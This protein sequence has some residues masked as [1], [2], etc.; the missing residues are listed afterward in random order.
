MRIRPALP[1]DANAI[2]RVHVQAWQE[3]YRG[4]MPDAVLDTISVAERAKSWSERIPSLAERRQSVVVAPNDTGELIGFAGCGP[5]RLPELGADGEIYMINIV[6]RGKRQR[7][8][9]ALMHEMAR[10]LDAL[11]FRAAGL[12]VLEANLPARAFYARLGGAPGIA[13]ENEHGGVILKD[14]AIRWPTVAAL[15]QA[16]RALL[17]GA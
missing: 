11:G 3:T 2:A 12:W 6:N 16:T 14:L 4:I 8:G 1:D 10:Q 17:Q 5:A 7:F 9:A 15:R 13:I